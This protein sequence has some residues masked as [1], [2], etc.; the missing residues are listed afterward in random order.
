MRTVSKSATFLATESVNSAP[1]KWG[2]T[3]VQIFWQGK[4]QNSSP[5]LR[6][7]FLARRSAK[8][9]ANFSATMVTSLPSFSLSLSVDVL[10]AV[11]DQISPLTFDLWPLPYKEMITWYVYILPEMTSYVYSSYE[12]LPPR[13]HHVYITCT[14]RVHHV[15]IACIWSLPPKR[16]QSSHESEIFDLYPIA[17]S[18]KWTETLSQSWKSFL[19]RIDL[20][21][22]FSNVC[23]HPECTENCLWEVLNNKR[24]S[25]VYRE[26]SVRGPKRQPFTI[27][28]ISTCS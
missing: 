20:D 24:T 18:A 11:L 19:L 1:F 7:T 28:N 2:E 25:W 13:V 16:G 10:R 22:E 4:A 14:S 17:A 26:L 8:L 27:S 15:N 5:I 21:N 23:V 12:I 6:C 9:I 3:E